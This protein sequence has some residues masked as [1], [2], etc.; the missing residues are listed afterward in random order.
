MKSRLRCKSEVITV[1]TAYFWPHQPNLK[2]FHP[3]QTPKEDNEHQLSS[4]IEDIKAFEFDGIASRAKRLKISPR[5][6]NDLITSLE[7]TGKLNKIE[8]NEFSGRRILLELTDNSKH[9]MLGGIEHRFWN[10]KIAQINR[11]AGFKVEIENR[12]DNSTFVD[13]VIMKGKKKIAVEIETGKSTPVETIVRDISFG[14]DRVVSVATNESAYELI[15]SG[16]EKCGLAMDCKV[17]VVFAK[18]Y[19]ALE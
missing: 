6:I 19:Q 8:I 10:H 7:A 18:D 14:F 12:I 16:I 2:I 3:S 13:Q 5:K 17:A 1:K 11:K 15:K 9:K 4:L